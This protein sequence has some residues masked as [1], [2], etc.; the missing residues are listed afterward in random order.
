MALTIP[1]VAM[2]GCS[3]G[4]SSASS[5]TSSA[6]G[7]STSSSSTSGAGGAAGAA[8]AGKKLNVAV[9]PK[10]VGFDYWT[11]VKAGAQCAAQ[12]LGN[13]NIEWNGVSAET[14]VTGQINM[15][16]GYLS[17]HVD[18]L[19]YAATDAKAL[20]PVTQKAQQAKIPVYNI[21]SGTT[22]QTVPL[23]ATDNVQGAKEVA[24]LMNTALHGHGKV[25]LLEFQPGSMTNDQRKQ[26]FI[27]G[28]KKYPG[29][30]L[31]SDQAD[32]SDANQALNVT[33]N[34]LTANPDLNGLFAS[35]EP[36]V[37]GASHAVSQRNLKGKV[38]MVGWDAAP[39]EVKALSSGEITALIVQNPF[40]MGF[41]S[42]VAAVE[43]IRKG[44]AVTK[45]DTGVYVVTTKNMNQQQMK[46]ILAPSCT[47]PP[48]KS[49]DPWLK[50]VHMK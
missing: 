29:L 16:N 24:K 48:L 38:V 22:P 46:A 10:A 3:N 19:I 8:S 20:V 49:S 37:I 11:H 23:F 9:I 30:K 18:A 14:D 39:D 44:V 6:P 28:L 12:K 35:N 47:N 5:S 36:G 7:S 15:L 1:V 33:N 40:R 13:V 4:P 45:E 43:H 32:Q 17:R 26:G 50:Y 27:E 41:D 31:V 2:A 42:V 25:A 34:I 21:D